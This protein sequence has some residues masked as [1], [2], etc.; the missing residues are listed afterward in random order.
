M[1]NHCRDCWGLL[2]ARVLAVT[3]AGRLHMGKVGQMR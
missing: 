3:G 2:S 1:R